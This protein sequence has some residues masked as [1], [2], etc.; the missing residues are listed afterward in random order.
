MNSSHRSAHALAPRAAL[1]IGL[2]SLLSPTVHAAKA[3][4]EECHVVQ[5]VEG[6]PEPEGACAIQIVPRRPSVNGITMDS[7][8]QDGVAEGPA[9]GLQEGVKEGMA[10]G[11]KNAS[12]SDSDTDEGEAP[13]VVL[14]D[15]PDRVAVS[16]WE[17]V[18]VKNMPGIFYDRAN[19]KTLST[20]PRIK[21]ATLLW[22][23]PESQRTADGTPYASASEAVTMDCTRHTYSVKY[24]QLYSDKNG[25]RLLRRVPAFASHTP[26]PVDTVRRALY[27]RVCTV[28]KKR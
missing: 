1:L 18:D 16:D 26:T 7:G 24:T 4:P 9:D 15:N 25:Q 11:A 23:Y 6:D 22:K 12:S 21:M 8:V 20:W 10:D 5:V 19:V 13:T 17:H 3:A 27:S 14:T 2:A 28:A